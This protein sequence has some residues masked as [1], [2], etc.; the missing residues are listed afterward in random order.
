F[1]KRL[2]LL[3]Q[4]A[5][6]EGM[7]RDDP[8]FGIKRIKTRSEG[9]IPWEPSHIE[10]FRNCHALG[11]RARLA[12]ELLLG[13][14]QRR[15]DV[16]RMGRQHVRDGILSIRQEKTGV[17]V[18]I[19]LMPELVASIDAMPTN[20]MTFIVTEAGKCMTSGGFGKWFKAMC[21][22]ACIP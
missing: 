4:F 6:A 16:V 8:T 7:R 13:T 5:V 9:F 3:M 11:T 14:G 18:E 17:L 21:R 22:E 15:G 1:L 10:A 19:P 2:H 12:L 20:N